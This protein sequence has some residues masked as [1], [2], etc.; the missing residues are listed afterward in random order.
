M[1][2]DVPPASSYMHMHMHMHM[3]MHMHMLHAHAHVHVGPTSF[4]VHR[5]R[6]E[7]AGPAQA[8]MLRVT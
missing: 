4:S 7:V 6:A 5:N 8:G 3:D 2:T 1:W